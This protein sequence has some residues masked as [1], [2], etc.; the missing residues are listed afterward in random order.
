MPVR[1]TLLSAALAAVFAAGCSDRAPEPEAVRPSVAAEDPARARVA[2]LTSRAEAGDAA[3]QF[4]LGTHHYRGEG[5]P[6]D[7][8]AAVQWWQK[9]ADQGN[10]NAQAN[11]GVAYA[12]GEGVSRDMGRAA[13]LLQ[14]AAAQ[15]NP[16]A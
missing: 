13:D 11:L 1:Q 9:A 10:P 2:A 14:K 5:T 3:A 12:K 15:G 8:A 16:A 4:D 6:R 7:P